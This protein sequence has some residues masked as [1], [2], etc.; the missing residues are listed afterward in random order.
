MRLSKPSLLL[1]PLLLGYPSAHAQ[2][3][4]AGSPRLGASHL[5]RF[6][7]CVA[8]VGD[9][10]NDQISD[11]AVGAPDRDSAGL[12]DNGSVFFYSGADFS[13]L[14]GS[15]D[16]T[17]QGERAGL[18]IAEVGDVN[19]D[20]VPD[21]AIGAPSFDDTGGNDHGRVLLVS[22]ANFTLLASHTLADAGA[23]FG[24][25]LAAAGDRDGDGICD[26]LVGAP[27][28][29]ITVFSGSTLLLKVTASALTQIHRFEGSQV[30]EHFGHAVCSVPDVNA[31]GYDEIAIS[32]PD[33]DSGPASIGRVLLLSGKASSNYPQLHEWQGA[34]MAI[35]S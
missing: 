20:Q 35:S 8:A 15:Y 17:A 30:N 19:S 1:V 31:D 28:P 7:Q 33:F 34:E 10:N 16:G 32:A 11:I 9:L 14:L 26:L 4:W 25:S 3:P 13:V 29:G 12:T 5:D 21:I 6:G 2:A 23:A 27:F 18:S 24:T 22:G